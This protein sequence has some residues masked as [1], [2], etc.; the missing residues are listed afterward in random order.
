MARNRISVSA[1]PD[2]VFAVLSDPYRYPEWVLGTTEV[3]SADGSW[4]KAGS[5]FDY[6]A[7][8]PPLV[9]P[10]S[11]EV[12]DVDPP[13]RLVLQ[14]TLP[15]GGVHIDIEI[16]PADEGSTI[17]ITEHATVPSLRH[18]LEP[19]FHLR[20]TFTLPSL[21]ANV[22]GRERETIGW[23]HLEAA[24]HGGHW[25][26]EPGYEDVV[27][28][29]DRCYLAVTTSS[30]P[31][32]TPVAFT[33]SSGRIWFASER[34][35]LKVRMIGRDPIV[36]VLLRD[37]ETSVVVSGRAN[38]F[39]PLRPWEMGSIEKARAVPALSRY[40]VGVAGRIGGYLRGSPAALLSLDPTSRVLVSIAPE[41]LAL[42]ENGTVIDRRGPDIGGGVEHLSDLPDAPGEPFDLKDTPS[43][44]AELA[45]DG[46]VPAVVGWEGSDGILALPAYWH[47]ERDLASVP[48]DLMDGSHEAPASLCIDSEGGSS[49]DDQKGLL[50]R[51]GG[52]VVATGARYAA[53]A[54]DQEKTTA[55][56]AADSSTTTAA[57]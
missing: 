54:I 37:E 48:R 23:D 34:S 6:R 41:G 3:V 20:N 33:V 12:V 18:P 1:T 22:E 51:G 36:G 30:G 10:G 14:T 44:V 55:W 43:A 38:V 40:L 49:L 56:A 5:S 39:D 31:H 24:G 11:T 57:N 47:P 2:E 13:R 19:A 35:S 16:H 8:P 29:T 27:D 45:E 52:R 53:I 4:P 42:V 28:A 26:D 9:W 46:R 50:I 32:V 7:G 21:K 25:L 17:F 15:I